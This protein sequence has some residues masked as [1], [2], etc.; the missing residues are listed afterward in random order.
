MTSTFLGK[1]RLSFQW[2]TEFDNYVIY[3][4]R[5]NRDLTVL[6]V[7]T[8]P[9]RS[10]TN[11]AFIRS[12]DAKLCFQFNNGE[13][14]KCEIASFFFTNTLAESVDFSFPDH[15]HSDPPTSFKSEIKVVGT[16]RF[17]VHIT[18]LVLAAP[19][20]SE[21]KSFIVQQIT[22][23]LAGV[24]AKGNADGLDF[25]WVDL[26]GGT[27]DKVSLIRSDF[28]HCNLTNFKFLHC[29]MKSAILNNCIP[30]GADFSGSVLAGANLNQVDL[31][32][33]LVNSPLPEF[34][35]KPLQPPSP[36]NPRTTLA[37]SCIKQSLLGNDW[38]MLDLTGATIVDLSSPLSSEARPLVAKY[39]VLTSFNQNN[40]SDLCL[41][42]AVFDNAKLDS[43]N[44]N[45]AD[46]SNASL[47]QASMHGTVL[48]NATL[49]NANMTGAQLGSLGHVFTLPAD[50][51]KDLSAGPPV[52]TALRDQFVVHGITLSANAVLNT[53]AT[54]RVWQLNDVGNRIIYTV[55]L[56][57]T[58]DSTQVLNVYKPGIPGSLVNAYMPNAILTGANLFGITANNIQFYGAKA[59]VDGSAILEEAK[60]NSSN[61]STV[62]FTQAQLL[63]A[64]LSNCDL[65]NAKFNKANLTPSAAGTVADLSHANLQGADF[66]D[67]QLYGANLTNAAVA[68][69]VPTKANPKQGGVYLCSLPYRGDT[70][71]LDQYTTELSGAA[72]SFFS[73][74]P[75]GDA[76]LLQQYLTALKTNNLNPLK[77]A[78]LR[79]HITLSANAQIQ[80]VEVDLVWQIVDG[81][82][83]YTLWTDVD[84]E[85]K[86][87]LYAASSLTKTRAAFK[88]SSL[89]LRWQASAMVETAVQQWLVDNDSENPQNF[90][91][92]YVKFSVKLNGDVLD[93]FGTALRILRMG[94]LNQEEFNTENCQ[95]TILSQT[96]M[97]ADTVCPNGATLGVNQSRSGKSWDVLWLRAAQPPRPPDCVPTNFNWCPQSKM[98]M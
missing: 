91:T 73:F 22:P 90:S 72:A 49:K 43:V 10:E 26:T 41:Q 42:Y 7:F 77:I 84:E 14:V 97:S 93:V 18:G 60:L 96:N 70:V 44:L 75:G 95:I 85:G 47:I 55:R 2:S 16:D 9:P 88:R 89:T 38:S 24:Q 11:I 36:D 54:G 63:G 35:T 92:G 30:T 61:L 76:T 94:D 39:S 79:H 13:Y 51:E 82:Q 12:P 5:T 62:N 69:N 33:V 20:S 3:R 80:I 34:Y 52:D 65:F 74:N 28:S 98:K 27:L 66:T 83:N 56:E 58:S 64:N 31:T 40:L 45:G 48:S 46:L 53:L 21:G 67:A 4:P 17:M 78:F 87:E 29:V 81:T 37:G 57:T 8:G 15:E 19:T 68:I 1:W 71:T 32:G 23:S 59:R 6:H 50:Y 86:T 25:G